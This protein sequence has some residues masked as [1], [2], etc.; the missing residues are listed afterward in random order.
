MQILVLLVFPQSF[1]AVL[2]ENLDI[3]HDCLVSR[4]G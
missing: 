4:Y 2:R 3:G 1:Y